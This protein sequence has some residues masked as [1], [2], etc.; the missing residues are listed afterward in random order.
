MTALGGAACWLGT[1][2]A[3]GSVQV[4]QGSTDPT[5]PFNQFLFDYSETNAFM[6]TTTRPIYVDIRSAGEVINISLCGS[7]DT[8]TVRIEIYDPSGVRVASYVPVTSTAAG[9]ILCNS[10]MNGLITNAYKYL[11]AA[12]GTYQIRIFNTST[13]EHHFKRFDITVTPNMA[14]NPDPRANGG[15][16]W[17]YSWGFN[18]NN[19]FAANGA[20]DADYFIRVPGG[21]TSTEYIWKLDL[22]RFAGQRYEIIANSIGL[23]PPNSG[24]SADGSASA[25]ALHPIYLSYPT[26]VAAPPTLAPNITNF[27]FEGAE[28]RGFISPGATP[29]VN[30]SGTFKFGTD[31]DGTYAITVDTNKDGVF[32]TGDRLLSGTASSS[33]ET[34]VVWDGKDTAGN[35]LTAGNY[36]VELKVRLG[37]YHFTAFDVETSG[38]GVSNG[39]TIYRATSQTGTANTQVYWDDVTKL[40]GLGGTSNLPGGG[41][42]GTAAGA[43]TWGNYSAGGLGDTRYLDTYV[44]GLASS[45][46]LSARI[47]N[48]DA[49]LTGRV[50]NDINFN[51]VAD[52]GETGI[53]NA[54]LQ[55]LDASQNLVMS[56]QTDAGGNYA[57]LGVN[58]GTYTVRV[59]ADSAVS[60]KAPTAPSPAQ[61]SV[62]VASTAVPNNNFGFG[63]YADVAIDK[64]APAA[65]GS[66]GTMSYVLRV[67]NN[68]PSTVSAVAVNDTIPSGFKVTGIG[69]AAAGTATCGSQTFTPNSVTISTGVLTL[70]TNPS[71]ATPDGNFL[72][73]TLTGTAP[74]NGLLS[75]TA[76]LTVPSGTTDNVAGNNSTTA[77]PVV[78][79]V[80][81]A[82]NDVAVIVPS[83]GGN[84]TVLSNDTNGAAVATVSNSVVTISNN[85]GIA[86]LGVN[87]G[88]LVVPAN[89]VPG[90]YT[91][92]YKLCDIAVTAACDTASVPVTVSAPVADLNITKTNGVG[93]V[94]SGTTTTYTIRVTNGG[95]SSV[96]GAVL[97]DPAATGLTQTAAACTVA[98]GNVCTVNPTPTALQSAGGVTLPALANGAFYEFTVTATVTANSG[99]VTNTV[100]VTPPGGTTDSNMANNSAGDTDT[101]VVPPN[102][103]LTKLG[104]NIS[105]SPAGTFI[106]STGSIGVKPG[107]T[108][109]YC[110]VY[111]NTGGQAANFV[112][113]DYVP[114]GMIVVPNAYSAGKGVRHAIGTTVAVGG[115]G[116]PAGTDLTNA[117]DPDAGTLDSTPVTNPGDPAGSPQ[118][119][120][121]LTLNLGA[122]GVPANGKGTVCFQTRVP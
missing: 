106:G 53:S 59:V 73:Y 86:S 38:G 71:N 55:L 9:K 11:T 3:E 63:L 115:A 51:G 61:R 66:D 101:V 88:Q 95:P 79:R 29:G 112:L 10:A 42:S 20:T 19:T 16:V 77:N 5:Q 35:V 62:T 87:N 105:T 75:N 89:T 43:H 34:A 45:S 90:T 31:V 12:T 92:T 117:S 107:E 7:V 99:S 64:S 109:E 33:A 1:A 96:T 85:G 110:I 8:D 15:R 27:R 46:L 104:R 74:T 113:K 121:L 100:T 82:V 48:G 28:G 21:R 119:P 122:A 52:S 93:S 4:S 97:K 67:W 57:F 102:I 2:Q 44:Y 84:V 81:D 108:V 114:L 54:T 36:N 32:G 22:N 49:S 80:I 116:A 40:A 98:G 24:Y 60:G 111:N 30:D 91:V 69:C 68:G 103:T 94:V 58:A 76:S 118:R 70:D 78:T 41:T 17:A 13:N 50:Y 83:S 25:T 14:T 23:N 26:Q 120:G 47:T 56:T 6:K 39:L 37:E 72:T 65:V 18:G